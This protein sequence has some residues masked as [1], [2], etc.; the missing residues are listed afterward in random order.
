MDAM[1]SNPSF[2]VGV[3][4]FVFLAIAYKPAKAAMLSSL[5][6]KIEEIKNQVEEAAK[7]R[8]EAQSLLAEYERKQQQSAQHAEEMLAAA[9]H[10]ADEM[11]K[12]AQA[13]L[14][15]ALKRQEALAMER[16]ELAEERA[17]QEVRTAVTEMA[18]AATAKLIAE[19]AEGDAG[20]AL[21][22]KSIGELGDKLH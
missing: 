11:K 6:S 21:V 5:D 13:D 3:S 10:D 8:D 1:L 15:D 19:R 9:K 14:K 12:R 22:E 16:I 7:L 2:W 18:I 4:F 20:D 17:V